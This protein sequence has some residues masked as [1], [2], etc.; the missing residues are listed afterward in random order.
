MK[1]EISLLRTVCRSLAYNPKCW[2]L[3]D[4]SHNPGGVLG[5]GFFALRN[6]VLPALECFMIV[7]ASLKNIGNKWYG[8]T[9]AIQAMDIVF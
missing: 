7:K 6:F 4:K 5:I 2:N 1:N 9:E 8:T 3:I